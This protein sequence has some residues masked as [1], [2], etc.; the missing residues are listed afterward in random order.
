MTTMRQHEL[1][2]LYQ[3]VMAQMAFAIVRSPSANLETLC[4]CAKP[5]VIYGRQELIFFSMLSPTAPCL[6][7]SI[8]SDQIPCERLSGVV[9]FAFAGHYGFMNCLL[10]GLCADHLLKASHIA[11]CVSACFAC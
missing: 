9:I 3:M 8:S 2:E 7:I 4:I 5:F 1:A 6:I 10:V 11:P